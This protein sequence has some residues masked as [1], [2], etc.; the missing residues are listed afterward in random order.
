L[1]LL[2]KNIILYPIITT[3]SYAN[4]DLKGI[5]YEEWY[6]GAI[7]FK[8]FYLGPEDKFRSVMI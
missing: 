8:D 7:E 5:D 3:G 1:Q 4:V 2:K 6:N